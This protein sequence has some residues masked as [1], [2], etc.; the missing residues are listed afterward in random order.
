MNL[1]KKNYVTNEEIAVLI[2]GPISLGRGKNYP[3]GQT[4]A[5]VESVKTILPGAQI[6]ISTWR[7]MPAENLGADQ[8]IY[9]DDPG[10]LPY[11]FNNRPNNVNRQIVSMCAGLKLVKAKCTLKLRSDTVLT[12]AD[13]IKNWGQY[14]ARNKSI[15]IFEQRI[16]TAA[17]LT[18]NPRL[19]YKEKQ[20]TPFLFHVNDMIQFGLTADMIKLWDL[21]L[22]ENKDFTYFSPRDHID[23]I[24][25]ITCRR[26]PED[27]V[28]TSVLG[29]AGIPINDSWADFQPQLLDVSEL[30][31]V[32]N[33]C[34]LDYKDMG[35]CS[36][37][38]PNFEFSHPAGAPF[39]THYQWLCLYKIYCDSSII[40]PR[41][42]IN[43]SWR[44][45]VF[46]YFNIF[47]H[48]NYLKRKTRAFRYKLKAFLGLYS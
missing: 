46:K 15:R 47:Y 26:V 25:H 45:I 17:I 13:L 29:R 3:N 43:F 6:I 44:L 41:E 42:K 12:S 21:P 2:H 4:V 5:V 18:I 1:A 36:L 48:Y 19:C 8:V 38:Y 40:V 23:M 34:L 16:M 11:G 27:Y 24:D 10:A 37:K 35:V 20:F 9:S 33:F 39:F 30:S 32:N 22:M 14:E 7:G 28:W 31:I